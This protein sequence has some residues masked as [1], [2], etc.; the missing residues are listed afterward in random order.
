MLH[1]T[2]TQ[3]DDIARWSGANTASLYATSVCFPPLLAATF[4]RSQW[5]ACVAAR[6]T[7][8]FGSTACL[9]LEA[10][11]DRE[12]RHRRVEWQLFAR[13]DDDPDDDVQADAG[14]LPPKIERLQLPQE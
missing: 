6:K 2:H 7:I 14:N 13:G 5:H 8:R 10:S 12:Q 1:I 3:I 9:P 11:D 4:G